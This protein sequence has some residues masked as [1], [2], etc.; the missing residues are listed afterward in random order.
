MADI[1][2]A[3][4]LNN[5]QFQQQIGIAVFKSQ[6]ESVQQIIDSVVTSGDTLAAPSGAQA[7]SADGLGQIINQLI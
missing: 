3:L 2:G 6:Q 1:A 4:A 5:L 7:L